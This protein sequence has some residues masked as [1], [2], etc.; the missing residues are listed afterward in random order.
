LETNTREGLGENV[1]ELVAGADVLCT[2]LPSFNTLT[3]EMVLHLNVFAPI[4]KHRIL[5]QLDGRFVVDEDCRWPASLASHVCKKTVKPDSLAC[6][7][8]SGD[9][10][11]LARRESDDPLLRRLPGDRTVPQPEEDT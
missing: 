7:R 3:D 10:L 9:V 8:G 11:C 2:D 6:R 4:V 1:S 5:A